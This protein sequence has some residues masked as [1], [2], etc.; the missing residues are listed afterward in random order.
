MNSEERD[1]V[2]VVGAVGK[3]L[4]GLKIACA[5]AETEGKEGERDCGRET[6][7]LCLPAGLMRSPV[8]LKL[9]PHF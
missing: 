3:E 8:L 1:G 4:P 6:V 2:V 7:L 5:S 9:V